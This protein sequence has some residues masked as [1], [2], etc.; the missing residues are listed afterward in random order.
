MRR[1]WMRR[2]TIPQGGERRGDVVARFLP[3]MEEK[4]EPARVTEKRTEKEKT[5]PKAL[6]YLSYNYHNRAPRRTLQCQ[7]RPIPPALPVL[8][9]AA[10]ANWKLSNTFS[11]R[12]SPRS[13]LFAVG[14]RPSS[15]KDANDSSANTQSW[16]T[17][18]RLED[19]RRMVIRYNLSA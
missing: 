16:N 14:R 4:S 7:C 8:Y 10:T 15:R 3:L 9:Q 11:L 6:L 13:K 18:A 2:A 17:L 12:R 1:R 5:A 19:D